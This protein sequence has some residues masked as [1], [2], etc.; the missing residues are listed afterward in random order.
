MVG[1]DCGSGPVKLTYTA[2]GNRINSRTLCN[3][4]VVKHSYTDNN[5][6]RMVLINKSK[7]P[8]DEEPRCRCDGHSDGV[9]KK[10]LFGKRRDDK[11]ETCPC[12]GVVMVRIHKMYNKKNIKDS[13]IA[14]KI[15][16]MV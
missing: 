7:L 10:C 14:F 3:N 1:R 8:A 15:L 13:K 2:K 16:L 5:L 4:A 11:D 12:L 9:L 6:V